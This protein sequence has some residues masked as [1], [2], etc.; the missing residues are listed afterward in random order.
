MKSYVILYQ[1]SNDFLL[2]AHVDC[3]AHLMCQHCECSLQYARWVR[4]FFCSFL[5][6]F[7]I[8]SCVWA[9][10]MK[11]DV[12]A[13]QL[14]KRHDQILLTHWHVCY[15][16]KNLFNNLLLH[17]LYFFSVCYLYHDFAFL[18]KRWW[19]LSETLLFL[20]RCF[21]IDNSSLVMFAHD[22]IFN[23]RRVFSCVCNCLLSSW[24]DVFSFCTFFA[25]NAFWVMWC[26]SSDSSRRW[27]ISFTATSFHE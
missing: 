22:M 19:F 7:Q 16:L 21:L 3:S 2:I 27:C 20:R 17:L 8:C 10:C 25:M 15:S 4:N 9:D 14:A 24:T 1:L 26:F 5:S 18:A 6:L 12:F 11:K 23:E 13:T